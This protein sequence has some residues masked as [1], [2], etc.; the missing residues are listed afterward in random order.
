MDNGIQV[1][2]C[3]LTCETD[4]ALAH[5]LGA[6]AFGFIAYAKSP[7][8]LSL[9][10]A[11]ELAAPI[12]VGQRIVV[13]VEPELEKIQA[14]QAAGFKHFQI[15]AGLAACEEHLAQWASLIG[16]EQLWI[17][18]R[19]PKGVEFPRH[20]LS[21]VATVLLDTYSAEQAGGTGHTGDWGGFRTIQMAHPDT[22]FILAGGLN[23]ENITTALRESSARFIDVNSGVESAP[24]VKDPALLEAFFKALNEAR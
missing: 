11:V 13:D 2:V 5:K 1:K 3:G 10:R 16:R 4:L 8:A 15:H 14:Y 19:L 6:E 21:H 12:P 18:P 22:R 9:E 17:A 23:P 20:V 24:G 7:R